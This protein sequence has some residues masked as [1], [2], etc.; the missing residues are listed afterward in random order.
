V[1]DPGVDPRSQALQLLA[2]GVPRSA[3]LSWRVDGQ[4]S[5]QDDRGRSFYR[6]RR[7]WHAVQLSVFEGGHTRTAATV[8]FRVLN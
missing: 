2:E 4:A 5:E 7:G 1:L 8:S 3:V 6:L